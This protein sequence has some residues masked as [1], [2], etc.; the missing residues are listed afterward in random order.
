VDVDVRPHLDLLDLDGALLLARLGGLFLRL[1][2]VLTVIQDLAHRR[3]RIGRDLDEI[4]TGLR[5]PRERVDNGNYPD[6]VAGRIDE[7]DVWG[8]DALVDTR[9]FPIGG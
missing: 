3:L 1:I 8:V 5:R 7:L 9:A 6:I 2:F 4:E